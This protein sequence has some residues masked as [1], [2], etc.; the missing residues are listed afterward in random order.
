MT[1]K[2]IIVAITTFDPDALRISLPPLNRFGHN[3]TLI[4]HNDNPGITLT[5]RMVRQI[6]WRG[7]IHIINADRNYGEM[8]SRI[9][10]AEFVREKNISGE[11]MVFVADDDVLL[12]V[13][14]PSVPDDIFAVLYNATTVSDK[15]TELFKIAPSWADGTKYGKTGPH[16]DILGTM[17]RTNIMIEYCNFLRRNLDRIYEFTNS[18]KYYPPFGAMMSGGLNAYMHACHKNMS[19]IYMNKTNYI[20]IKLGRAIT[21][22]GRRTVYGAV[23]R[24]A[25]RKFADIVQNFA[26]PQYAPDG[27]K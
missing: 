1:R 17:V 16:F 26:M 6:G 13:S 23:A 25:V 10:I 7:R 11:W 21:K 27:N 12:D 8:E 4:V 20:S 5:P 9:R 15:I 22:Y 14:S 19:P 3:L 18:V 24:G 2:N